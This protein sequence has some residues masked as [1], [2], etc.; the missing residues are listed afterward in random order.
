MHENIQQSW[1]RRANRR[2]RQ[3][4]HPRRQKYGMVW[5][6]MVWYGMVMVGMKAIYA[7]SGRMSCVSLVWRVS[8]MAR[9]HISDLVVR[10]VDVRDE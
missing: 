9:T 6:G 8:C 4:L 1:R 5:Y 10:Q 7:G 2:Q 3:T